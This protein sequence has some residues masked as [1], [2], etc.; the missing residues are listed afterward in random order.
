MWYLLVV[1]V[2]PGP[3]VVLDSVLEA[4]PVLLL[5]A[6]LDAVVLG[7]GGS[8][9][10]HIAASGAVL[11][12]VKALPLLHGVRRVGFGVLLAD[13]S[14]PVPPAPLGRGLIFKEVG[15]TCW[16]RTHL[17]SAL[18]RLELHNSLTLLVEVPPPLYQTGAIW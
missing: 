5:F 9:E 7:R 11:G 16:I 15:R 1:G 10:P 8:D 13:V 4:E 14:L 17:I 12:A 18:E 6:H 2:H 3:L